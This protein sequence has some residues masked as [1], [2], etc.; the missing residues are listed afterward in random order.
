MTDDSLSKTVKTIRNMSTVPA[1][2]LPLSEGGTLLLRDYF[3]L[4]SDWLTI[5][6]GLPKINKNVKEKVDWKK[7]GF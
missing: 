3:K 1:D 4:I 7:E 6:N 2:E 5:A